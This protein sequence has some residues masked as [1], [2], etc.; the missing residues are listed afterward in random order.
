MD[1]SRFVTSSTGFVFSSF[2][3]YAT[4][5]IAEVHVMCLGHRGD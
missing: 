5:V 3:R 1:E 2:K 4:E